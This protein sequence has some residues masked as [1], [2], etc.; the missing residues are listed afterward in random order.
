MAAGPLQLAQEV[1]LALRVAGHCVYYVGGYVRDRLLGRPTADIDLCT[2]APPARL[3]ELFP[4]APQVG[5]HFGVVLVRRDGTEVQVAT[6]RSDHSYGDGRRP[7]AVY[8]RD[9][10]APGRA[11]ARLHHQRP[12]GGPVQRRNRGLRRA[13]G[14]ICDARL[15]R[16]IG[17][18]RATLRRGPSAAAAGGA[19]RG[20]AGLRDR[21]RD[22]GR[23]ARNGAADPPHRARAGARRADAHP[24][25]R[26]RAARRRTA[27]FDGPV[28]RTCCPKWSA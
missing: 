22:A 3:L 17:E 8:L 7:E 18:P 5:A 2:D 14:R 28:A 27:G 11:A 26:R 1:A 9:G 13:A 6:F 15:I 21:G 19:I 12:A 16:A 20:P 23:D 24:D 4:G 25:R 10:S